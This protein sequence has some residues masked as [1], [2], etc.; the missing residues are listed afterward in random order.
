VG[1]AVVAKFSLLPLRGNENDG[2]ATTA[3]RVVFCVVP[4]C[5][6]RGIE[7]GKRDDKPIDNQPSQ[8]QKKARG[9]GV[10]VYPAVQRFFSASACCLLLAKFC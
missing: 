8:A 2:P 6:L 3:A 9:P 10:R 5:P 1:S 7:K 4:K